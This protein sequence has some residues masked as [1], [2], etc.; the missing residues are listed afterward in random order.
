MALVLESFAYGDVEYIVK[1]NNN[2]AAI[3][4]ALNGLLSVP[5]AQDLNLSPFFN[6]LFE[7]QITRIEYRS[8]QYSIDSNGSTLNIGTG[9]VWSQVNR[10]FLES[11]TPQALDFTTQ[12][13]GT[14]Y[15]NVDS[16]GVPVV[17]A[18]PSEPLYR[19]EWDGVKILTVFS[20]AQ[21]LLE[22]EGGVQVQN[23]SYLL[24]PSNN[25]QLIVFKGPGAKTLTL[26]AYQIPPKFV[27]SIENLGDANVHVVCDTTTTLNDYVDPFDIAPGE[28][29]NL[30]FDGTAFYV[31]ASGSIGATGPQGIQGIQGIQGPVGPPGPGGPTGGTGPQGPQGPQG[32]ATIAIGSVTTGTPASVTNSGTSANV[33][34]D[35]VIPPGPTGPQGIPGPTG[36]TGVAGPAG[37]AATISVGTV[38]TGAPGTSVSVTNEGTTAAAILDFVIPQGA[39]GPAPTGTGL[40]VVNTGVASAKVMSGDAAID[41]A[42]GIITFTRKPALIPF[43]M[44][45]SLSTGIFFPILIPDDIPHIIFPANF[46]NSKGKCGNNPNTPLTFNITRNGG[47][48]GTISVSTGGAFSF[49][50]SGGAIITF[51]AGDELIVVPTSVDLAITHVRGT[52]SGQWSN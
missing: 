13:P 50:S 8:Y 22:F 29:A 43:F 2:N 19:V 52:L 4:A 31:G 6:Y 7:G 24:E 3:I 30:F 25:T 35:F 51:N 16:T 23:G 28:G 5:G 32:P 14:Y 26:T 9:S 18:L 41:T 47:T 1:L 44:Y 34:L 46:A 48:V 49:A 10:R 15:I 42:T 39:A 20:M 17:N 12:A 37:A 21:V 40:V 33:I 27:V 38:T 11:V 36:P 45:G